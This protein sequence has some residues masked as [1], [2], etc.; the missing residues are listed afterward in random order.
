MREPTSDETE[1]DRSRTLQRDCSCSLT[2]AKYPTRLC[3]NLGELITS[4]V[5]KDAR[6]QFIVNPIICKNVNFCSAF[7]FTNI[8]LEFNSTLISDMH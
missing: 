2:A 7:A 3:A 8:S 4:M 5:A 6:S 1:Y